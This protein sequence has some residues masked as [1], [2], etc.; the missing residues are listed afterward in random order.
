MKNEAFS[1]KKWWKPRKD[2]R[3][4]PQHGSKQRDLAPTMDTST[5]GTNPSTVSSLYQMELFKD[6]QP[7][8][9][10]SCKPAGKNKKPCKLWLKRR[11]KHLKVKVCRPAGRL[12][13]SKLWLK[14]LPKVKVCRLAGKVTPSKL[15]LNLQPRPKFANLLE[16]LRHP[17]IK[18]CRL[19][20]KVTPSKPAAKGQ[21]LQTCRKS[22]TIQA[23]VEATAKNQGLQTCWKSDIVQ[24]SVEPVSKGQGLQICR[25]SYAIQASVQ[26]VAKSHCLY[27]AWK[28]GS[29]KPVIEPTAQFQLLKAARQAFKLPCPLNSS[30]SCEPVQ[31]ELVIIHLS[32]CQISTRT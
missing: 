21:C 24:A 27:A 20:G 3:A 8:Q 30:K 28:A 9:E 22:Y 29:L 31:R 13:P 25:R 15:W 26:I 1:I 10:S 7:S 19:A 5:L 23:L 4:P 6:N 17:K 14:S 18:V 32:S 16:D 11:S 2:T 12:T